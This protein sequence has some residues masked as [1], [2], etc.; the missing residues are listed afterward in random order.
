MNTVQPTAMEKGLGV[1]LASAETKPRMLLAAS[2]YSVSNTT[3]STPILA[4]CPSTDLTSYAGAQ[5]ID[6]NQKDVVYLLNSSQ[7]MSGLSTTYNPNCMVP[8]LETR[9][10]GGMFPIIPP[11]WMLFGVIGDLDLDGIVSWNVCTCDIG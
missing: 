10:G 2:A 4:M 3:N 11:G 7:A 5:T 8:Y 1:L 9:A 6:T